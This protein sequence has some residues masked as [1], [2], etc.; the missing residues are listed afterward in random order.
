MVGLKMLEEDEKHVKVELRDVPLSVANALRR[1]AISEVPVMAV[2]EV[3]IIENTSA[4]PNE[5]LAHR[6]SLIPFISDIDRYVPPEECTCGSKLGCERCVVRYVLR[7]EAKDGPLTV[8]SRDMVPEDVD[9]TVKPVS[10]NIPIVKLAPGERIE[11]ELYLR[12]GKGKKNAKWQASIATLYEKEGDPAA[13][14]LFIESIGFLPARR[15]LKEAGNIFT[16]KV[17]ELSERLKRE[18]EGRAGGQ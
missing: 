16:K 13:R 11:M 3:L 6:I 9:T 8:Y 18:L 17:L 5:V 7:A 10:G 4:M 1:L 14:V 15:I 12:V 2:E